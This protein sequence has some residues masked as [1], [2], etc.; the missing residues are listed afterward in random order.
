MSAAT[1]P[2]PRPFD[3]KSVPSSAQP[4]KGLSARGQK[5]LQNRPYGSHYN[6]PIEPAGSGIA[7]YSRMKG[8]I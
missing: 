2:G 7:R 3:A 4:I 8:S 6:T 1:K 5:L